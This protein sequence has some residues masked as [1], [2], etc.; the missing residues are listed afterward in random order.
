ML[1]PLGV[2]LNIPPFL[3]GREQLTASEVV[4]TQQIASFRIHVERAICRMKKY[5][6]LAN[7]MPASLASFLL[8]KYGL[9]VVYSPT[10]TIH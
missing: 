1:T 8:T 3:G 10:L 4:D 6:I 2:H 7:V 5:D 9:F